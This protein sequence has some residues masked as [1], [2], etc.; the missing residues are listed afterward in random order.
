MGFL[1][2][3]QDNLV[4]PFRTEVLGMEVTVEDVELNAAGEIVAICSRGPHRQPIAVVDLPLPAE[5]PEG[6]EWID[7]Y[8]WWRG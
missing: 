2:M 8:R 5:A 3:M 4:V 6:S 7:A 1:T